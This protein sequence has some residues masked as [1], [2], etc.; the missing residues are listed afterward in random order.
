MQLTL[1]TEFKATGVLTSGILHCSAEKGKEPEYHQPD[2]LMPDVLPSPTP[3]DT[4]TFFLEPSVRVN[5]YPYPLAATLFSQASL[6]TPL[7]LSLSIKKITTN[8]PPSPPH[9]IARPQTCQALYFLGLENGRRLPRGSGIYSL[10][11]IGA[12][13]S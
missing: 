12:R 8:H 2:N 6:L 1:F 3:G 13:A 5:S 7:T 10:P 11:G 4:K 9:T